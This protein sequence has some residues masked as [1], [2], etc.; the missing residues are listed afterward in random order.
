MRNVTNHKMTGDIVYIRKYVSP[1]G[2][3]TLGSFGERL[4]LCDWAV[5]QHQNSVAHRLKKHLNAA[6][7]K[8]SSPVLE[9]AVR[10]LDEYFSGKRSSFTIPL[11]F[12]GTAFQTSVWNELLNVP[13]GTSISYGEL[14]RRLGRPSAIRAV[15]NASG[16]NAISIFAP[17]HR[18]IG[19]DNSLT[20]YAGGL[21]AKHYL[22]QL[23]KKNLS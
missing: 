4:C 12:C 21:D 18:I 6:F 20:G 11:L 19:S 10:Q 1:C 2:E 8:D 23:E 17:C 13:Y 16:A 15:A 9:A 5:G 14:A 22:L 7:E 3:L